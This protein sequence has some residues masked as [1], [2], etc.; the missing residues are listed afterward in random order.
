MRPPG[1]ARLPADGGPARPVRVDPF[2]IDTCAV[3]NT[4]FADFVAATG[5]VTD[6]APTSWA[7]R[8]ISGR[9]RN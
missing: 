5:Y 1:P 9:S 4:R 6:A 8:Y 2:P 7:S 3:S